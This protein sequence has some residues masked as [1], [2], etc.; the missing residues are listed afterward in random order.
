[1]AITVI[2]LAAGV[3]RKLG[4]LTLPRLLIL[5]LCVSLWLPLKLKIK[6]T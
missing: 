3:G 4:E 5:F 1:M 2:L 6:L